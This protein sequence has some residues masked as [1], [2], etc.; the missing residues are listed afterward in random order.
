M[1]VVVDTHTE[2]SMYVVGESMVLKAPT[3]AQSGAHKA[4]GGPKD[5]DSFH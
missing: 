1:E 2:Q 5:P 3:V 4:P